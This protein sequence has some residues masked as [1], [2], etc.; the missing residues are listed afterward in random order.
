MI[1]RL[2]VIWKAAHI[3][4]LPCVSQPISDMEEINATKNVFYAK[5]K[6]RILSIISPTLRSPIAQFGTHKP[7]T[8]KTV[9]VQ[10]AFLMV[11]M[12]MLGDSDCRK[13]PV[14]EAVES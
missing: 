4:H 10:E 12:R 13:P 14:Y 1:F 9:Q 5:N 2:R 6:F 7:Q 8:W 11:P 3:S